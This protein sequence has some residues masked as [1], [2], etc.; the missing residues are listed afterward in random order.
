MPQTLGEEH[1]TSAFL[2]QPHRLPAGVAGRPDPD[3][4]D[5]VEDGAADAR[6]V[7]CL[8]R[9]NAREVDA[10]DDSPARH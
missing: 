8:P 9:G 5:H 1:G 4:N 6:D 10:P 7:L 2:I 3:V